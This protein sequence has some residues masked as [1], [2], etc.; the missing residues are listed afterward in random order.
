GDR[1]PL[2]GALAAAFPDATT[3]LYPG[4]YV[5]IAP[6][7]WFDDVTYLDLDRRAARF[8]GE[9]GAV[10]DLVAERR[11]AAGNDDPRRPR[12]S[13]LHGDYRSELPLPEGAF[14]LLVSLYAGFISEHCTRHL[15]SGG[16]LL[17]NSSHG[18]AAMAS[19]DTRY[20]LSGVVRSSGQGY[21][22][23]SDDLD[24]YL[25][26]KKPGP[27]DVEALHR[28][29]RGIAYTRAAFAYVFTRVA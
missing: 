18:D 10:G 16:R 15:R 4:S 5:D 27:I 11:R 20:L 24:T 14:D 19:I 23:S 26:P 8:F 12:V 25:V 7:V 21:D 22:L 28:S 1:A 9:A 6:S 17:V 29:G 2:F 3:V 13:F